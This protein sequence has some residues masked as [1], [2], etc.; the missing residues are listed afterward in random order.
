MHTVSQSMIS[1]FFSCTSVCL[2][3]HIKRASIF[4]HFWI[5]SNFLNISVHI[6][7]TIQIG[8]A[9]KVSTRFLNLVLWYVKLKHFEPVWPMFKDSNRFHLIWTRCAK[10]S[11]PKAQQDNADFNKNHVRMCQ[12]KKWLPCRVRSRHKVRPNIGSSPNNHQNDGFGNFTILRQTLWRDLKWH[13]NHIFFLRYI[14]K[15]VTD[16]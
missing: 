8:L 13:G 11:H 10:L 6:S 1:L 4:D 16:C 3:C 7:H 5:F 2:P 9:E 12:R 15:C 14:R